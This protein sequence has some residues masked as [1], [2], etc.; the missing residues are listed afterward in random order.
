M[1]NVIIN[2]EAKYFIP[3]RPLHN[4]MGILSY[5]RS[6]DEEHLV[7]CELLPYKFGEFGYKLQA[8]AVNNPDVWETK[9]FYTNDFKQLIRMGIVREKKYDDMVVRKKK[10]YEFINGSAIIIHEEEVVCR[11]RR[12][13]ND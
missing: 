4:A 1:K 2:P 3:L 13:E 6:E 10:S 8:R 9:T 5:T 11:P 12:K 7:E